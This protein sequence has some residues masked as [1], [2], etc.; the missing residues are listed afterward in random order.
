MLWFGATP[1]QLAYFG[2]DALMLTHLIGI[3]ILLAIARVLKWHLLVVTLQGAIPLG[4]LLYYAT[5]NTPW[6]PF[7]GYG[8]W[9]FALFAGIGYTL[10]TV[11]GKAW[12]W[13][14]PLHLLL[15]WFAVS[16]LT[17]EVHYFFATHYENDRSLQMLSWGVVPLL[18]AVGLLYGVR[19]FEKHKALYLDRGVGGLFGFLALWQIA[20]FG[21]AY[22][23]GSLPLFN[24]LDLIQLAALGTMLY[25]IRQQKVNWNKEMRY[26]LYAV[27]AFLGWMLLTVLF[28]RYV[29]H[30]QQVPYSLEAL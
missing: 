22:G 15:F 24:P 28:A 10:L 12:L 9:T 4:V 25:W 20:A 5:F 18:S 2:K 17:F 8:F 26:P 7:A 23:R 1:A 21:V 13:S 11:Y 14:K 30:I 3:L 19:F 16:V 6:H 29:H 27:A